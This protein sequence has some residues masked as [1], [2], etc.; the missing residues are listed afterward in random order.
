MSPSSSMDS[1]Y[2]FYQHC[3]DE[4]DREHE[5]EAMDSL[6]NDDS[7]EDSGYGDSLPKSRSSEKNCDVIDGADALLELASK[8]CALKR[9]SI[10][11]GKGG[12]AS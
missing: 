10:R 5:S 4:S 9:M 12:S 8:A 3:S 11:E 6:I 1:E 7:L 2:E